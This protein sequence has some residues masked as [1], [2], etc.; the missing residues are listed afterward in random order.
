M[1]RSGRMQFLGLLA[2]ALLWAGPSP[3]LGQE[4]SEIAKLTAGDAESQDRFGRSVAIDGDTAVV[5][6]LDDDACLP[7]VDP[8]C[9][10]GAAYLFL[11]DPATG[12]W[13]AGPKLTASDG[14]AFDRFGRSVAISGDTVVVGSAQDDD[15]GPNSGSAYVFVRPA[16]GWTSV[17]NMTEDAKLVASDAASS[18]LFGVSVG[19]SGEAIVVG[20]FGAD[21]VIIESGAAYIFVRPVT[22]WADNSED[23]KLTA[24]DGATNDRFGFSVGISANTA[25]VGAFHDD[26]ACLPI[27]NP[28]CISGSAYIFERPA[29]GWANKTEDAKLTASDGGIGHELGWSVAV[30]GDTAVAGAILATGL[31][32]ESGAAYV[33]VRPAAGWADKTEDAKLAAADGTGTDRFGWA[34]AVS[35]DTVVV[36][37]PLDDDGCLPVINFACQSGSAYVFVRPLGGWVDKTGDAK[38]TASDA[39]SFHEFGTT[40]AVSGGSAVV[41]AVGDDDACLPTIDPICDSGSAYVFGKL[42]DGVL[43][44]GGGTVVDAAGSGAVFTVPAGILSGDTQ[45][46]IDVVPDPGVSP[47]PGFIAAATLFVD[48]T[49]TPNP[50]PLPAPGAT[51]TL[52]LVFPL[53]AGTPLSLFRFDPGTG[54]LLNA[55][56]GAVDAGGATATFTGVTEFSIYVGSEDESGAISIDI[57]PGSDPNP[58]NL[59]SKGLIP[60]AI[61]SDADFNAIT[62]VDASTIVFG[63]NGASPAHRGHAGDVDGDGDLDALFHFRTQETGIGPNDD[64]AC[65]TG[66]TAGGMPIEDCDTIRI[67]PGSGKGP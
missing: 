38:M 55:G 36:G 28:A 46:S 9:N 52:P 21:G 60:V 67:T 51:I 27:V 26:D 29:G 23:A 58:I 35:G 41:G 65:L 62:E 45:V 12:Q 22:G 2:G 1:K 4:V 64:E 40:V 32:G 20:A 15:A 6:S 63:P 61:L 56:A 14:V 59:K 17:A 43:G 24:G 33:F 54:T 47:P 19:V 50:S 34:V 42:P 44:V 11:R 3:V 53:P 7:I 37:S 49:L 18:H 66:G 13:I 39:V 8:A 10:S 31:T 57:R 30:S 5:G 25:V 16:G 48:F